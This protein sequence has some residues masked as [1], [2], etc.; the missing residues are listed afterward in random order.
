MEKEITTQ[1]WN[2]VSEV[3][4][5]YKSKV[6]PSQR[7]QIKKSSDVQE[8]LRQIWDE[9]KIEL[10]EQFKVIL[11]NRNNRVLGF[12]EASSGG[13]SGTVADPKLIF[14][15]AL[16]MNACA[17]IIAHNHPSGNKLPSEADKS[18]TLKIKEGAKLL[19]MSLLDHIIVTTEECFSFADEGLL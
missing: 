18:L 4:L 12:F 8:L 10:M 1:D 5:V 17:L 13:V 9:N 15:A 3:E 16:K 11:L 6:K 7:L 14:M 19:D 2:M